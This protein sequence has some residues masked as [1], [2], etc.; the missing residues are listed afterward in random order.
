MPTSTRNETD[1]DIA[2]ID[3]Q[4]LSQD[5]DIFIVEGNTTLLRLLHS[6]KMLHGSLSGEQAKQLANAIH[7]FSAEMQASY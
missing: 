3:S 1:T 4:L 5:H 6:L 7:D 2:M